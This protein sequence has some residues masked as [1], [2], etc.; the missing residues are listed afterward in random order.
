[1]VWVEEKVERPVE[2]Q[3]EK[4]VKKVRHNPKV[5]PTLKNHRHNQN[6]KESKA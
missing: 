1:M 5:K 2:G 3:E 6:L 4:V